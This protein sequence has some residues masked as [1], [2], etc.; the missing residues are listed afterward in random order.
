MLSKCPS[1][2]TYINIKNKNYFKKIKKI[3]SLSWPHS[4]IPHPQSVD[5]IV[6][7]DELYNYIRLTVYKM[8]EVLDQDLSDKLR[9]LQDKVAAAHSKCAVLLFLHLL[10]LCDA[11]LAKVFSPKQHIKTSQSSVAK[12]V[13]WGIC[14]HL[15]ALLGPETDFFRYWYQ[16][17]RPMRMVRPITASRFILS[18]SAPPCRIVW[19]KLQLNCLIFIC[20]SIVCSTAANTQRVKMFVLGQ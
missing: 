1:C 16:Y 3:E 7:V 15:V 10:T 19:E 11:D 2:I 4:Y 5:K 20:L 13:R 14:R 8:I 9:V 12:W 6:F 18:L 17:P